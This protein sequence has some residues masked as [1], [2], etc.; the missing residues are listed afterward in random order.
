MLSGFRMTGLDHKE[1][2]L[3]F[4][5]FTDSRCPRRLLGTALGARASLVLIV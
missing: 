1:A 4:D 2:E 5:M 3:S